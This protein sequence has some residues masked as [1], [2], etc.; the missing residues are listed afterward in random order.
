MRSCYGWSFSRAA[1]G[2]TANVN[3]S[4]GRRPAEENSA[5][6]TDVVDANGLSEA[7]QALFRTLD[8]TGRAGGMT[9]VFGWLQHQSLPINNPRP[10]RLA[11]G[12]A[13]QSSRCRLTVTSGTGMARRPGVAIAG[14]ED[15]RHFLAID[16]DRLA[17]FDHVLAS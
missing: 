10:P 7:R 8:R 17:G 3:A 16:Q 1:T 5:S 6:N 15:T 14:R 13:R 4:H 11:G 12:V 2:L 9:C